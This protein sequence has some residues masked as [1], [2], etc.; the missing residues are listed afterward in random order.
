MPVEAVT[1]ILVE[2]RRTANAENKSDGI[3][4]WNHITKYFQPICCYATLHTTCLSV[5]L[6]EAV[7]EEIY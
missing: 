6:S 1:S 4:F 5:I 2:Q 3:V 7:I